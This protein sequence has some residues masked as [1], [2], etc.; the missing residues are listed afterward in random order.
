MGCPRTPEGCPPQS[1]MDTS[2]GTSQR[3]VRAHGQYG[4]TAVTGMQCSRR[5]APGSPRVLARHS[6]VESCSIVHEIHHLPCLLHLAKGSLIEEIIVH[7]HPEAS[8]AAPRAACAPLTT[9]RITLGREDDGDI[10]CVT[11]KKQK[12]EK[13]PF[14]RTSSLHRNPDRTECIKHNIWTGGLRYAQEGSWAVKLTFISHVHL[15]HPW[16]IR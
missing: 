5:R 16:R 1:T 15:R 7:L 11:V 3:D 12:W 13:T 10:L 4:D 2:T 8:T 6:R 14:Q 9:R